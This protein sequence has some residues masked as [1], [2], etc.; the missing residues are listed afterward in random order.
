LNSNS[1]AALAGLLRMVVAQVAE[2]DLSKSLRVIFIFLSP[3]F[4][5]SRARWFAPGDSFRRTAAIRKVP[6]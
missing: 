3:E 4:L 2:A 1:A 5:V 6:G